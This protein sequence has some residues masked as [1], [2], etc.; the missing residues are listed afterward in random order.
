[1]LSV[2]QV[3]KLC[4][5]DVRIRFRRKPRSDKLKGEYDPEDNEISVY[6]KNIDSKEERDIT[7]LHEFIHARDIWIKN[8]DTTGSCSERVE[9]EATE[10]YKKRPEVLAFIKEMYK[11]K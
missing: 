5:E 9:R 11:I 10:T 4:E 2:E 1:M 7:I 8:L 6:L 3:I